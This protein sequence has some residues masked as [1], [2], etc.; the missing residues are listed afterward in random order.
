MRQTKEYSK[1]IRDRIPEIIRLSGKTPEVRVLTSDEFQSAV[2]AKLVEELKEYQESGDVAE[3]ADLLETLYAAANA[4]GCSRE[5]LEQ[6][7]ARKAEERGAFEKRLFLI[8]VHEK[9]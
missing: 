2:D 9:E 5:E 7:R 8:A 3:L 1:L 4:R 6:I